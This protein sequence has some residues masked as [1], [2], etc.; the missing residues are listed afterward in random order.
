MNTILFA[1]RLFFV[2]SLGTAAVSLIASL[3]TRKKSYGAFFLSLFA[4]LI[5]W[6]IAAVTMYN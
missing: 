5:S 2:V 1:S 4:A 3:F 6:S